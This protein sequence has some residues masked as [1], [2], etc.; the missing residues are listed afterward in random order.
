AA[1]LR[2][3]RRPLAPLPG[4]ERPVSPR[5]RARQDRRRAPRAPAEDLPRAARR[6]G[7]RPLRDAPQ[8]GGRRGKGGTL[9][10]VRADTRLRRSAAAYRTG[11]ST[12]PGGRVRPLD[13][14]PRGRVRE[15][16][17]ALDPGAPLPRRRVRRRWLSPPAA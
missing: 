11:G 5:D 12:D 7:G 13:Y 10:R 8:G 14:P 6:G 9:R 1:G 15:R 17:R 4:L 3:R 2:R 16:A